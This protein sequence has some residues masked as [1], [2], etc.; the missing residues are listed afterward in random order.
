[1][2]EEISMAEKKRVILDSYHARAMSEIGPGGRFAAAK[3]TESEIT[4]AKSS[5]RYPRSGFDMSADSAPEPRIYNDMGA[6]TDIDMTT[7]DGPRLGE[8]EPAA[9]QP[10]LS[11]PVAAPASTGSPASASDEPSMLGP[12]PSSTEPPPVGGSFS[13]LVRRF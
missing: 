4:G 7:I 11:L 9:S 12:R 8:P 5:A 13:K 3:L 10:Q 6:T 1:M 2:T